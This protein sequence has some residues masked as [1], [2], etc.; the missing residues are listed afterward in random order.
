MNTLNVYG[1]AQTDF[2]T[3]QQLSLLKRLG[4]QGHPFTHYVD[5]RNC[6]K[7]LHNGKWK[8]MMKLSE[9][10]PELVVEQKESNLKLTKD[11]YYVERKD[12]KAPIKM[13]MYKYEEN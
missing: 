2:T 7:V 9:D 1:R 6:V 10:V 12:G 4:E 11:W 3:T 5:K 8:D 13:F